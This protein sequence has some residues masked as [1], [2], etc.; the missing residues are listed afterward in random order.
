MTF[1]VK[2]LYDS[3]AAL[4]VVDMQNDFANPKGSLYVKGG[5]SLV[6]PINAAIA[7]A[8]HAKSLI[9]YTADWHPAHTPHFAPDGGIWPV[10]CVGNSWGARFVEG[11]AAH[12]DVLIRKGAGGEDGYSGF[13]VRDV[14]GTSKPTSLHSR[15]VK[16]GIKRVVVCGLATDYCVGATALDAAKL[17]YNTALLT[18]LVA[19][20]NLAPEDGAKMLARLRKAAV[21]LI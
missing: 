13:S 1:A 18:N 21:R 9:V 10:H 2:P 6:G 12:P 4:V 15:L 20:V 3:R 14:A 16:A 8:R 7:T 5:E 11:L 19:A 17:G